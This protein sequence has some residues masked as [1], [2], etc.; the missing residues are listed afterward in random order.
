MAKRESG[1]YVHHLPNTARPTVLRQFTWIEAVWMTIMSVSY[2]LGWCIGVSILVEKFNAEEPPDDKGM[3][4]FYFLLPLVAAGLKNLQ[5]HYRETQNDEE[6]GGP[7]GWLMVT[8]FFPFSPLYRI[9]RSWKFGFAEKDDWENGVRFV[10]EMVTVG[11]LRLFDVFLGDLPMLTLLVRDDVLAR[12]EDW[13]DMFAPKSHQVP[14]RGQCEYEAPPIETWTIIRMLILLS[15][16][17]QGVTLYIVM[18]KRLQRIQHPERYSH[19]RSKTYR[20]GRLNVLATLL[21]YFAHFFFIASR[22]LG[23]SMILRALHYWVYLIAGVRWLIHTT[24]HLF[25]LLATRTMT[26]ARSISSF[27]MGGV[28]LIALT[29][30]DGGKQ[31]GRY[32]LYYGFATVET[33]ICIFMWNGQMKD[34]GDYFSFRATWATA[35]AL[36]TGALLHASYYAL[37]HPGTPS[38]SIEGL[39]CCQESS[40]RDFDESD[41][42]DRKENSPE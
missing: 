26:P 35:I 28:W 38:L 24:W 25:A 4:V 32:I 42:E 2:L 39:R 37:L 18:V 29:N 11:V 6:E 31:L 12:A 14:C 8:L 5:Y 17:A 33:L 21:L 1:D 27:T 19:L 23:Y 13:S 3:Y 16:M 10:D 9:F 34:S 22:I 41:I 30:E 40:H 36:G 7:M 15:K 20:Q